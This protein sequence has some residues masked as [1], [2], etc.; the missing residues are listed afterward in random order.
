MLLLEVGKT[1]HKPK[2]SWKG[3]ACND[4]LVFLLVFHSDFPKSKIA[5]FPVF[6]LQHLHSCLAFM[7]SSADPLKMPCTAV[8]RRSEKGQGGVEWYPGRDHVYPRIFLGP[9][10]SHFSGRYAHYAPISRHFSGEKD[11]FTKDLPQK[12]ELW[13]TLS[14]RPA[15]APNNSRSHWDW[16]RS[17][18][19]GCM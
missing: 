1:H 9:I 3:L 8:L 5:V 15:Q 17:W 2:E 16:P 4:K 7:G 19:S 12:V 6:P 14:K 10:T 11:G 13:A 18:F